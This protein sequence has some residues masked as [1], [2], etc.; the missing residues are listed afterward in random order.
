MCSDKEGE[1]GAGFGHAI[2]EILYVVLMN[3]HPSPT[4]MCSFHGKIND[5]VFDK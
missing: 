3:Y 4:I 2:L 5:N 1:Q